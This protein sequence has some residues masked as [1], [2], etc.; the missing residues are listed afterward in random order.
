[1][2]FGTPGSGSSDFLS[3]CRKNK[4]ADALSRSPVGQDRINPLVPEENLVAA[5][6]A[7]S[8][9]SKS[10]EGSL[11][12]RQYRDPQLKLIMQHLETGEL[13]AEEKK[14]RS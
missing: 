8:V 4:L 6:V 3:T 14:A 11:G 10:R 1:M 9:S 12:E 5:V 2:M 13:P 7:P